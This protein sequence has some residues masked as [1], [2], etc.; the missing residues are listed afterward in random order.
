[1]LD[2]LI[3]GKAAKRQAAGCVADPLDVEPRD[4]LLE[5]SG[6]E[7]HFFLRHKD[8]V[9]KQRIPFLAGEEAN[10]LAE[11]KAFL[12][13]LNEDGTDVSGARAVPHVDEE[14]RRMQ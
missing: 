12:A 11:R 10:R 13:A 9:K 1:M 14:N 6:A 5:P 3:E 8:I 7:Q 2:C 4:L